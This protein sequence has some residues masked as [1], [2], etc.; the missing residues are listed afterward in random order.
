MS[1]PQQKSDSRRKPTGAEQV[2]GLAGPADY[3]GGARGKA[4]ESF[5]HARPQRN[6]HLRTSTS[7]IEG[8]AVMTRA[9]SVTST[10]RS[11]QRS[12]SAARFHSCSAETT[13]AFQTSRPDRTARPGWKSD[14]RGAAEAHSHDGYVP[15]SAGR[16]V[17]GERKLRGHGTTRRFPER[18]E[19]SFA[20]LSLASSVSICL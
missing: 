14:R 8:L 4:W 10:W 2:S 17:S 15:G 13:G 16:G 9:A 12:V 5:S 6:Q 1:C 20:I 7:V 11:S 18:P 3:N 19:A